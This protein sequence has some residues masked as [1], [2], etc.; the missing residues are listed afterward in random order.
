MLRVAGRAA[1]ERPDSVLTVP[2]WKSGGRLEIG[3]IVLLRSLQKF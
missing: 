3:R 2:R 1:L